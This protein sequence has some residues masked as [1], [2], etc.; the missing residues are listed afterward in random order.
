MSD[1]TPPDPLTRTGREVYGQPE[2]VYRNQHQTITRLSVAF[3]DITKEYYIT[4]YGERVGVV[5]LRRDS[6]LLVR[7]YR[8]FLRA[9]QRR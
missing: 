8:L 6:V 7:Q 5:L 3:P 9:R 2:T 4:D 1:E